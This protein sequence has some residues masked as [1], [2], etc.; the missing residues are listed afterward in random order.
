MFPTH[1]ALC[2]ILAGADDLKSSHLSYPPTRRVNHVDTYH[3]V[4]VEDP[5]RWLEDDVRQS[6][7]VAEWVKAQNQLTESYLAAIPTRDD[8]PPPD[9]P[10]EL[11]TVFALYER[12]RPL[13]LLQ[14]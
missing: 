10:L 9:G 5:Y 3:G 11:R 8:P 14:E 13:F 6:P 4:K 1:I 2:R 12:G 7:E